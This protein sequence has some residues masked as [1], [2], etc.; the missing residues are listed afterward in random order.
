MRLIDIVLE[1]EAAKEA[2][3][4]GLV[5]KPGVALYG[6]PGDENPA[7]HRSRGGKL[8]PLRAS[9][10][11]QTSRLTGHSGAPVTEPAPEEKSTGGH[12]EVKVAPAPN[13]EDIAQKIRET[14][15][16]DGKIEDITQTLS[17]VTAAF[18]RE[19]VPRI[20]G[21]GPELY[22]MLSGHPSL[23]SNWGQYIDD[24]DLIAL[25]HSISD[26]PISEWDAR[27]TYYLSTAIHEVLHSARSLPDSM[28]DDIPNMVHRVKNHRQFKFIDEGLTQY[29]T[30]EIMLATL[31]D[32]PQGDL[33][34]RSEK[35]YPI[36]TGA[37]RLMTE[38]GALDV[39]GAFL[40]KSH[41]IDE[42]TKDVSWDYMEQIRIA[43]NATFTS[44]LSK[45][46]FTEEHIRSTIA[47]MR[48]LERLGSFAIFDENVFE[49]LNKLIESGFDCTNPPLRM[50]PDAFISRLS[51]FLHMALKNAWDLRF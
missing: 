45:A 24:L 44:I 36:E 6:P 23:H 16:P 26:K 22:A 17:A 49:F 27:E 31:G 21:F 39:A 41:T 47:N 1:S 4:L 5:K 10:G 30:E 28:P 25:R 20:I 9:Q 29:L 19:N 32:S 7:T 50:E 11:Q 3:K 35:S 2:A 43:H 40:N 18:G 15:S 34:R 33:Y 38:Y 14:I 48:Q 12:R 42:K 13:I 51:W 37:I 46:G 8:V